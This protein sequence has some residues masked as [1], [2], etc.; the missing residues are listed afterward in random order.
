MKKKEYVK[1]LLG[2]IGKFFGL[3]NDSRGI[4]SSSWTLFIVSH[5]MVFMY[6]VAIC[7]RLIFYT[8]KTIV[9]PGWAVTF[10]VTFPMFVAWVSWLIHHKK[11]M[12]HAIQVI[13]AIGKAAGKIPGGDT[14]SII[15]AITNVASSKSKAEAKIE[16]TDDKLPDKKVKKKPVKDG[17]PAKV[18]PASIKGGED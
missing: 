18:D 13:E 2:W 1:G 16:K 6:T 15:N 4:P 12:T 14:K 7:Y 11:L 10:V 8:G 9:W 5:L 17:G 3:F